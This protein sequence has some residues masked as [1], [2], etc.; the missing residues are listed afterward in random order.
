M[1]IES[2]NNDVQK[3]VFWWLPY[4]D[5]N[6]Y[7]C[8]SKRWKAN[9]DSILQIYPSTWIL[10]G[11]LA[12][13]YTKVSYSNIGIHRW[14]SQFDVTELF[15]TEAERIFPVNRNILLCNDSFSDEAFMNNL[16]RKQAVQFVR[17]RIRMF[18]IIFGTDLDPS[19]PIFH[20]QLSKVV[21]LPILGEFHIRMFIQQ[22]YAT[23]QFTMA[24]FP[25]VKAEG[26]CGDVTQGNM[27]W[28]GINRG[29]TIADFE[30]NNL[31]NDKWMDDAN[32]GFYD[33]QHILEVIM[34]RTQRVFNALC[35][36]WQ[37]FIYTPMNLEKLRL[38]HELYC[39]M[40]PEEMDER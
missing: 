29:L 33:N 39:C 16:F 15:I 27:V 30:K 19:K 21:V 4:I 11:L 28:C 31:F 13:H 20:E 10:D 38:Q 34:Y 18:N 17:E 14:S 2:V 9:I 32:N 23:N 3:C 36:D 22:N 7:R 5:L 6:R 1:D 8:V 40:H 26:E 25:K 35:I 24:C 12:L 37:K